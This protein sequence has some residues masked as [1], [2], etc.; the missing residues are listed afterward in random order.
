MRRTTLLKSFCNAN[1][2]Y[3]YNHLRRLHQDGIFPAIV[4]V[5]RKLYIDEEAFE[6]FLIDGGA[7]LPGGWRRRSKGDARG[8]EAQ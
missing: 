2:Q 1:P 3:S 8:L 5:G 6:K 4:R 7:A